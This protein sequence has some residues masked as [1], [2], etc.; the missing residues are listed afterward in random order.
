[1]TVDVEKSVQFAVP[2]GVTAVVDCPGLMVLKESEVLVRQFDEDGAEVAVPTWSVSGLGEP[3]GITITAE[4]PFT[5]D[6]DGVIVVE[7]V[8]EALQETDIEDFLARGGEVEEGGLNRL[9]L[10]V[11]ELRRAV[12]RSVR[13]HAAD[14]A[15]LDELPR[16]SSLI[17]RV[18]GVTADGKVTG[19]VEVP[20]GSVLF[21]A[22]GEALA[23]AA[24]QAS[25]RSAIGAA[26]VTDL[27]ALEAALGAISLPQPGA[28]CGRLTLTSGLAV[29]TGDTVDQTVVHFTPYRGAVVPVWDGTRFVGQPFAELSNDL[30]E[31]ATGKAG[32]AAATPN[33]NYDLLLWDD[34]GTL[35]LTRGPL[36]SSDTSRGVGAGTSELEVVQGFEVNKHAIVNGPAAGAGLYVGTIRTN[37]TSKVDFKLGAVAAGGTAAMIGLWNR[38][39]RVPVTGFVGDTADQWAYNTSTWRAANASNGMRVSVVAGLQEEVLRAR[40]DSVAYSATVSGGSN[41]AVGIGLDST[42]VASGA[43]Q[44]AGHDSAS[45]YTALSGE[46]SSTL[47]GFHFMQALEVCIS[48]TGNNAFAGD[49]SAPLLIQTGLSFEWRF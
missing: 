6:E 18:L 15:V 35:R 1:M 20:I 5:E 40:Y 9:T 43:R 38:Y 31:S 33:K 8:S 47:L 19:L 13:L 46:Y 17:G 24:N 29:L 44:V 26:S 48:N 28:P 10:L 4:E 27:A 22:L 14:D 25:A 45:G 37:G 41:A 39:N 16:L 32:P 7:R 36:W 49:I 3:A 30:T 42:T 21:S 12:S 11:Q 34:A 2:D 23:Q